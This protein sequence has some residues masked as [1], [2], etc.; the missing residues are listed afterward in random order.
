MRKQILGATAALLGAG[1]L[2]IGLP[3][4]PT[5]G[6]AWKPMTPIPFPAGTVTDVEV[7]ATGDGDAVAAAIINGA[8]HAYTAVDGAWVGHDEVRSNV[9]STGLV[10]TA[11]GKGDVAVG[12][13]ENVSG[14][15][16][17][18]VSRQL[19]ADSWGARQLLTPAGSD[20]VGN[21]DIGVSGSGLVIATATVDEDDTDNKLLVTE[22][23]KAGLPTAP[24]VL[25]STDAWG[26]A[27]DVNAKGEAIIAYNYTGLIDDIVDVVRR[28]PGEGWGP[29]DSTGN[30]GNVASSIDVALSDN[31]QGHVIYSVVQNGF[32]VAETSRV[33]PD[34]TA[35]PAE[36]VAPLDEF[37]GDPSVDINATGSALFTWIAHK[38]GTNSVRYATAGNAAYPGASFKLSGTAPAAADPTALVSNSGLRVIQHTGNGQVVTHTQSN[39]AQPFAPTYSGNGFHTDDAVDVDRAGNAVMV[40]FKPVGGVQGRFFDA[41]GP[42]VSLNAIPTN[43]LTNPPLPMT[44]FPISWN[45]SDSLSDIPNS[46]VYATVAK[47]NE[48]GHGDPY[49]IVDNVE[50]EV[51]EV[52]WMLGTSYCLQVRPTDAAGNATTTEKQCTTVPL[53]D[54]ALIGTGWNK[55]TQTGNFRNTLLTTNQQG[56]TLT[57]TAV[58]AKRLAL[59]VRRTENGGTVKVTFAGQSLGSHS[60]QGTGKKKVINLVNF[61]TVESGELKIQ[62]VSA[63]GKL[64]SIDGVVIA[65]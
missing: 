65:K 24:K 58:K 34:G 7:V 13:E 40:G 10:L 50:G 51:A 44:I 31:G 5:Q 21:A 48:A 61:P 30:S 35:L 37:A 8:V 1:A 28:T 53:D 23:Q 19:A 6:A 42:T 25:S 12:W 20:L 11:N 60:L 54:R 17:L 59:V 26:P 9:E 45:M 38:D 52:P 63:D 64:V 16:R 47:W 4:S 15:L 57:R 62:V 33:L 29:D 22:W 36:F 41:T 27:L 46:D 14:D 18:G 39:V 3:A 55:V 43:M 2:S 32:Y 49:V 56:R